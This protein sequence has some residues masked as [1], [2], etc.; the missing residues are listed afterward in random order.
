MMRLSGLRP[1]VPEPVEN[2]AVNI[3]RDRL[4]AF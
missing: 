2:D 4:N 3:D 1:L